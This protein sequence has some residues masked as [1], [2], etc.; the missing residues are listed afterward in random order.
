MAVAVAVVSSILCDYRISP[1]RH[2]H[3]AHSKKHRARSIHQALVAKCAQHTAMEAPMLCTNTDSRVN[4]AMLN[5]AR[6][7]WKMECSRRDRKLPE[8]RMLNQCGDGTLATR[9]Q[10]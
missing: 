10:E 7:G 8:G 4:V 6:G 5:Y 2:W 9:Q 1:A 3:R